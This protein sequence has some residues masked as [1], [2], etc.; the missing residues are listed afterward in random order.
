MFK[1]N[2][3]K[4]PGQTKDRIVPEVVPTIA[5]KIVSK[6]DP[7]IVPKID[8]KIEETSP[9]KIKLDTLKIP[10]TKKNKNN[11]IGVRLFYVWDHWELWEKLFLFFNYQLP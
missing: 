4:I 11:G 2:V 3:L 9:K 10:G 1:T 7:K 6:I 5:S 8:T